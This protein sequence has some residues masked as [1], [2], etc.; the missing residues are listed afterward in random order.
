[1]D[2]VITKSFETYKLVN[3]ENGKV[4]ASGL[5]RVRAYDEQNKLWPV[6]IKTNVVEEQRI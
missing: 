6:G 4:E 3:R 2:A 5:Y 1:M